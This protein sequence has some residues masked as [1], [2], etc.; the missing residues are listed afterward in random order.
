MPSTTLANT[1]SLSYV[2]ASPRTSS[3]TATLRQPVINQVTKTDRLGR[4]SPASVL[5]ASDIMQFRLEACNTGQA[6]AY[7]VEVADQLA[8]QLDEDPIANLAVSVGGVLLVAGSDYTYTPPGARGGMMHFLLTTPVNS[9][10]CVTIDYDIG[11]HIDFGSNQVW[12]NSVTVGAY[13]SLP[14]Q[15]GQRYG[16]VGPATFSMHNVAGIAPPAKT[17]DSPASAEATIGEEIV[18]HI[19]IPATGKNAAMYDIAITDPLD[20]N[21][22]FLGASLI[23][24]TG[25]VLTDNSVPPGQVILSVDQIL[26][27]QQVVIA[28]AR[29]PAQYRQCQRR[30]HLQQHGPLYVR[31]QPRRPDRGWRH[32]HQRGDPDHRALIG[33]GQVRDQC[34]RSGESAPGR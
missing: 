18:Y 21:Q 28:A 9:G 11:F 23:S 13:W 6:P 25:A 27:M 5:V 1:A 32:R 33:P 3:A 30:R 29:P 10:Q 15:S 14:M 4:T 16:P 31:R 20:A 2:G 19:T 17:I 34:D 24:G 7:S 26:A 22:E 12:N 8:T